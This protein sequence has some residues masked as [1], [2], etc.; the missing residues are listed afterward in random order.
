MFITNTNE[1]MVLNKLKNHN[2]NGVL[3]VFESFDINKMVYN[4]IKGYISHQ[5]WIR[6]S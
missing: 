6:R 5:I 4:K 2:M 1:R 3:V